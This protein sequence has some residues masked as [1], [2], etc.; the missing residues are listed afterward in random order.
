MD[1][2]E[3]V[4][5]SKTFLLD[6][7]GTVYVDGVLIGGMKETLRRI[8]E[9][10]RNIVYLTNNS[11][12]TAEDYRIRLS[13]L[14]IYDE[15]D[16]IYTSGDATVS[17]LKKY[18]PGRRVYLMGTEKLRRAFA[19]D[20]IV[21]DCENP[22]VTVIS[23]DTE[24]DYK[25]IS[26][27]ALFL[28]RG[29]AYI[30]THPDVNCPAREADLP[31]IGSYIKLFEASTGRLPDVIVGKPYKYMAEGVEALTGCR[32]CELTMVGDR[33]YTDIRFAAENGFSSLLV[34][35]GETTREMYKTSKVKASAVLPSLNDIVDYL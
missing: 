13:S 2:K 32:G 17:Y 1:I 19:E 8:R 14:G 16:C 23:Y 6:L 10:G 35:S 12:R 9:S 24:I 27:V 31:D 26:S 34:L 30:A 25:K 5:K 28:K 3:L 21:S 20:G 18:H 22:D 33:L 4:G 29:T 7:D 15:R 11:S